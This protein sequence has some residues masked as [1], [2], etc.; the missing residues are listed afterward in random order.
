MNA[1][2]LGRTYVEIQTTKLLVRLAA[3]LFCIV[4]ILAGVL[5]VTLSHERRGAR[6]RICAERL[7]ALKAR[8][9]EV[10]TWMHPADACLSLE[11]VNR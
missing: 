10:A 3:L 4:T 6:E 11:I 8:N 9:P 5:A 1:A 2:I 7:L